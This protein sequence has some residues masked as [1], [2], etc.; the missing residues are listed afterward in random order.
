[1]NVSQRCKE[2]ESTKI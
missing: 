1:M 2:A